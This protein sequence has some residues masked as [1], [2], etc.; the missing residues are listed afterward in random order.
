MQGI[1]VV[2]N[3]KETLRERRAKECFPIIN[4]GK[5]WYDCL[6]PIQLGE[7]KSWYWAWL[8]VTETLVI[9]TKPDW[10]NDKLAEEEL[11]I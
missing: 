11:I 2:K 4:R 1:K 8:N 6:T 3:V 5:L 9:P 7:L 10:L